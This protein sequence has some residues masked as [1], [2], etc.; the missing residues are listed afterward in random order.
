MR[1]IRASRLGGM[2]SEVRIFQLIGIISRKNC[3]FSFQNV[4]EFV[5]LFEIY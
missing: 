4:I 5:T 2:E 3:R 1:G